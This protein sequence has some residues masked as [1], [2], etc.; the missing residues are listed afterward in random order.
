MVHRELNG[1][2]GARDE[3]IRDGDLGPIQLNF[4]EL[5]AIL[6]GIDL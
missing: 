3:G 5:W 1:R 6:K 4:R 2:K